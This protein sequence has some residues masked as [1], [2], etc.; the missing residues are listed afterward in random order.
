MPAIHEQYLANRDAE[1]NR[2]FESF[3]QGDDSEAEPED[4][5][6]FYD[7]SK[8]WLTGHELS[9]WR[10]KF[11]QS[12]GLNF[13]PVAMR[14]IGAFE[15]CLRLGL[16][17]T[18]GEVMSHAKDLVGPIVHHFNLLQ[19]QEARLVMYP[20]FLKEPDDARSVLPDS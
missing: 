20:F 8:G 19:K 12:L 1:I 11:F 2:I 13:L 17:P 15:Y 4:V 14:H 9:G 18:W 16:Y 3:E 10:Q 6:R 7:D 5:L